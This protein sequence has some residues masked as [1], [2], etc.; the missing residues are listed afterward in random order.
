M[1]KDLKN[2]KYI[3]W[4]SFLENADFL[5]LE[6]IQKYQLKQINKLFSFS[7]TS[8]KSHISL[9]QIKS[10]DHLKDVPF[11]SKRSLS[12]SL[13][14]Y[15]S[16]LREEYTT[17]GGSSG[18]PVGMYRDK[19]AFTKELAS[20]AHQY[21]RVGWNENH[22][23]IVLRGIPIK[24]QEKFEMFEEY[25]ELRFSSYFLNEENMISF[26]QKCLEYEPQWLRC[27]PSSG[28][29]FSE[30]LNNNNLNI[31]LMGVLCASENLYDYQKQS[32]KK[33]FSGRIFSHY[34]NY[35][36]SSL[37]GYCE[38]EDTYHFLPQYSYTEIL[39]EN[40]IDVRE[41]EI[42]EI[43]STSF[44][45]YGTPIIRYKT[46]D[47]G[48]FIGRKCSSCGRNHMIIESIEGRK[49]NIF[50]T[51]D[52]RP[53]SMTAINFHDDT[54]EEVKQYQFIQK[55]PGEVIIRV[56]KNEKWNEN[57]SKKIISNLKN[58]VGNDFKFTLEYDKIMHKSKRG[59]HILLIQE[60]KND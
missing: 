58:K 60:I 8:C 22:R 9:K 47:I 19:D 38:Y 39:D 21:Y 16:H 37:G 12:E 26:Y 33:A 25:N 3:S 43:V 23:Q 45:N 20:K 42:G 35:E 27:Y 32:M 54:F 53:I 17:T 1:H 44:I 50:Y 49:S 40:G 34:G 6:D 57:S 46:G 2:K 7:S 4:K 59:K 48:R 18:T 41:G 55:L 52:K 28:Y 56:I 31:P 24:G 36:L 14:S 15:S 29:I 30:W 5:S 51:K 13:D 11:M 10:L